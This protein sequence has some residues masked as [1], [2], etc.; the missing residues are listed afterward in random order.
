MTHSIIT[1][2]QVATHHPPFDNHDALSV[3]LLANDNQQSLNE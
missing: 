1:V 2:Q 3:S